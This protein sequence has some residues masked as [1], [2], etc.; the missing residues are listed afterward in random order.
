MLLDHD[1]KVVALGL[2][3]QTLRVTRQGEKRRI[4]HAP[5]YFARLEDGS[6]LDVDVRPADRVLRT[7]SAR[8]TR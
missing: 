4:S 5:D 7:G 2:A 8:R 3:S 1:R 6:G